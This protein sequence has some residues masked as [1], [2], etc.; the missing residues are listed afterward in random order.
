MALYKPS[1]KRALEIVVSRVKASPEMEMLSPALSLGRVSA[2][3]VRSPISFPQTRRA[4]MDGTAQGRGLPPVKI[5]TGESVAPG[6]EWVTM[7]EDGAASEDSSDSLPTH[8]H[9]CDVA[10]EYRQGDVVVTTGQLLGPAQISQGLLLGVEKWAVYQEPRVRVIVVG[11]A[12]ESVA[13]L[14]WLTG[15]LGERFPFAVDGAVV[16]SVQALAGAAAEGCHLL[17]VASDGAPGRY[18]ELRSLYDAPPSWF[19]A[20]FWKV[21]VHPCKHFGFGRFG[22]VPTLICPDNLYKTALTAALV[23]PSIAAA[24]FGGARG[25]GAPHPLPIS[26]PGPFP[27]VVPVV[28]AGP[29]ATH[30]APLA[31]DNV[32]SG[33][34]AVELDGL[35]MWSE[36][37]VEPIPLTFGYGAR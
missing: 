15:S 10:D 1:L 30:W 35:A 27:Y 14:H 20:D 32:F 23:T 25:A 6:F 2:G 3:I 17:V 11:E 4:E 28:R 12:A 19:R 26:V 16:P 8:K 9:I 22:D 37:G 31:T 18:R 29:C 5:R 36:A 7:E 34:G 13:V 21:D 24:L 33:R